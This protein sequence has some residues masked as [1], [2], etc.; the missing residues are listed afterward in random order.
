MSAARTLLAALAGALALGACAPL[1]APADHP[2]AVRHAQPA[3]LL[4]GRM[5][6]TDGQQAASGRIEWEHAPHAD[7]LTL[8][9]PLGQIAARLDSDAAG[10]TLLTADGQRIV[11][12][13]ADALLPQVLGVEVPVARLRLWVQAAPGAGAEIRQRDG[14]GRPQLLIDQ[15]W[16]IDYLA[17]TDDSAGAP[18]ARLDIS[19]G[20]HRIRL[21]IDS[22]TAYP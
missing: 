6:A 9:N 13:S 19:R 8:L 3:F 4:E 10:A 2:A 16:R 22:W 21:I 15:G 11:A 12:A 1:P 14:Y 17:Y 7:R 5:S 20:D 18:P